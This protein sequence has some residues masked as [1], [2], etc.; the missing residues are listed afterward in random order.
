MS[1]NMTKYESYKFAFDRIEEALNENFPFEAI[2]LEES[3]ITDRLQS[4]LETNNRKNNLT[5]AAS[6]KAVLNLIEKNDPH[7]NLIEALDQWRDNRNKCVHGA[8]KSKNDRKIPEFN[9]DAVLFEA[10]KIATDGYELTKKVRSWEQ[11][12]KRTTNDNA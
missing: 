8:V 4:F 3:I 6:I 5:F 9:A 2:V 11:K 10:H 12:T 7:R 1:K